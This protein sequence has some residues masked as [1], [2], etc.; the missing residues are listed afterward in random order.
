MEPAIYSDPGHNI[1]CS[2][3]FTCAATQCPEIKDI[4]EKPSCHVEKFPRY[5]PES[6]IWHQKSWEE[7]NKITWIEMF[8]LHEV[9]LYI[10]YIIIIIVFSFMVMVLIKLKFH[11]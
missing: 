3:H 8:S 6:D 1:G 7:V 5:Q 2:Y 11:F 4:F 9:W 10:L